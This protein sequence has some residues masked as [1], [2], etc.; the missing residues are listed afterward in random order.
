M[1]WLGYDRCETELMAETARLAA[2]A[3][4]LDPQ[5][6]VPTC[7]EW[8]VR[9]VVTHVGTG[10]RWAAEIVEGR[11][12]SPPPMVTMPAP[13]EPGSWPDW[14]AA[15]ARRLVDAVVDSGPDC[16][17]WTWRTERT[18]GSWLRKMLHD[19]LVHRC[20]VELVSGPVSYVAPDLAADGVSDLLA[21]IAV[22]SRPDGEDPVFAGLVGTGQTV[23]IQATD[24]GLAVAAWFVERTPTG[25]IWR[26]GQAPADVAVR[27]PVRELLLV[28]NRRLDPVEAGV[29]LT[30]DRALFTHWL[31]NS[32]F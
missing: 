12:Q 11:L 14:L 9:D 18:A 27:A 20:D 2:A 16:P 28:L 25:V 22:L 15:N 8:T 23:Q 31:E 6:T 4:A 7:P 19:E 30:G 3:C 13:Q 1:E 10:H 17:V 32:R 24:P 21:S 5:T 26:H 29:E